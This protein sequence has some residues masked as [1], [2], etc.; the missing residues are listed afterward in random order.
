MN[1]LKKCSL[2][3]R[4]CCVDRYKKFGYCKAN[5]KIKVSLVSTH[6]YEEPFISGS[7]GSGTIFF[8]NCNLGCVFCQ[9]KK[10]R[11]GYGKEISIKRFKEI[12][13]EQ[14]KRNVHNINLVTPT[15]YVPLIRKGILEDNLIDA[16]IGLPENLFYGVSIPATIV[17]FK[18]NR[19]NNDVLFIEASREYEK[20][21][22]QNK[23]LKEN[24]DKIFDT[25]INRKEIDKYS[26]LAMIN[27]IR[28]NEYN[29]NIKRYVDTY[30]PEPEVDI[31][32]TKKRIEETNKELA[33]LEKQLQDTLKE[34]GL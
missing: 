6:M 8:T 28:E 2:C 3:P 10:I 33:I 14:Q 26:H 20:G 22:N 32:E 27:E 34:L 11:D 7:R 17:V 15:H 13:L 5:A 29:L 1:V 19:K 25:Y 18:K 4:N 9:N 30:E 16:V 24:I 23:L 12:L 21:K 31:K